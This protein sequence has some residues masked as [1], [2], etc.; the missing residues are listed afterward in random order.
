LAT[1][2]G[3]PVTKASTRLFVKSA[4]MQPVEGSSAGIRAVPKNCLT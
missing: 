2:V 3:Q 1:R 4:R